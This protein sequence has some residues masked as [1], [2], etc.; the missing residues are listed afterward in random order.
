MGLFFS[1]TQIIG[2]MIPIIKIELTF[3]HTSITGC[4]ALR[5]LHLKYP[6]LFL[7]M[8][9]AS[10]NSLANTLRLVVGNMLNIA[11]L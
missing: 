1:T 11:A 10:R 7:S 4:N 8:Y 9:F 2:D 3:S 5:K 6:T